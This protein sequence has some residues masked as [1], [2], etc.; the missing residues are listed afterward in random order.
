VAEIITSLEVG[1]GPKLPK[2]Q[3]F[4]TEIALSAQINNSIYRSNI[5]IDIKYSEKETL[6]PHK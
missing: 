4:Q 3:K 1:V 6:S 2:F 5:S